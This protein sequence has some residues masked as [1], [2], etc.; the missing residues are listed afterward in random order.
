MFFILSDSFEK[1]HGFLST[2]V[3]NGSTPRF[4]VHQYVIIQVVIA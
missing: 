3:R 1:H 4:D 2:D